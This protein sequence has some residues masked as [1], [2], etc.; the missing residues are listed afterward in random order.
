MRALPPLFALSGFL[1][2]LTP[3]AWG[4]PSNIALVAHWKFDEATG[5]VAHDAAG[6]YDGQ[7]TATGAAFVTNG[8]AGNALRLD[9]G[10]NGY[11][12]MTNMARLVTNDFSVVIWIKMSPGDTTP[13]RYLISECESWYENGFLIVLNQY[14][15]APATSK[16][17]LLVNDIRH[18]ATATTAIND[19]A[20]HQLVAVYGKGGHLALYVD[21]SPA[22]VRMASPASVNDRGA[23]FMIG[24]LYGNE[25][26]HVP[27]GYYTGLLDDVQVY[28]QVLSDAQ[29]DALFQHPGLDLAELQS[30]VIITPAGGGFLGSV[31]VTLASS[32]PGA[33]IRYTLDGT[34]P[35]ATSPAY[36]VPL[37]LTQT[38][39]VKARLFVNDYPASEVVSAT[40]TALPSISFRPPGGLFTN[41]VTVTLVNNL[42]LGSVRYTT[43]GTDPVITSLAYAAPLTFTAATAVKARLFLNGFPISE[44]CVA[45]Y[46]RVYALDDGIPAAW[47]EHYFGP[48]Y[49]TDPRVGAETD[50][51]QDGYSNLLEYQNG[52]DPL[53]PDSCPLIVAGI[54][55]IPLVSWNSIPGLSYRVLRKPSVTATN[56]EVVL[57]AFKATAT[58]SQYIDADAPRTS[59]YQIELVP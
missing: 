33:K 36:A 6:H 12:L 35:L 24:G 10:Q 22:E 51:D 44:V 11:V 40:F 52:T 48:G 55:A 49:L 19:G 3:L 57:P 31:D 39:T 29:V 45:S 38:T 8:I 1:L 17:T 58:H 42:A 16:A 9:A 4:Q 56:W 15:S 25:I 7:L 26:T 20:W 27:N 54:R 47:R 21:G 46:A 34:D 5:R 2:S 37:T 41:S 14:G 59:L 18:L 13:A 32:V 30:P 23:P 50:A 53:D 43:D 28:S